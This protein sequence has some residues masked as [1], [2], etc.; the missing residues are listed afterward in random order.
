M[1]RFIDS[2]RAHYGITYATACRVLGV[3]QSWFYKWRHGDASLRHARRRALTA[4]IGRLFAAHKGKYGSPRIWAD[5]RDEGWT[6][7][8]NT[9]AKIMRE[10]GMA[11]RSKRRRRHCTRPGRCR[12]RALDLVKRKFAAQQLNGKCYGDGAEVETYEG[13]LQLDSVLDMASRRIIG[14]AIGEH[15]DAELAYGALSMAVAVRGGRQEIAGVTLHTDQG[16]EYTAGA[17]RAA[18]QRCGIRQSMGRPGSDLD[19]AV[20]ESWYSTLEFELRM[21]AHF[22]TKVQAR[23]ELVAWIDDYNTDRRHSALNMRSPPQHEQQLRNGGSE[24]GQAS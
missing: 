7:S 4:D 12:W 8:V 23:R 24:S 5:L 13:K 1:S 6:V 9:V 3:S 17:F 15:H 11:A 16:S 20:I 10:Q 2:Q 19:N 21:L 14:F 18:R 22:D